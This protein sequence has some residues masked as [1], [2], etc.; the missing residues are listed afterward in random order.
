M[1]LC[2][3]Y[4]VLLL[5]C[6]RFAA[7]LPPVPRE[8]NSPSVE[9][10]F[11]SL[12]S[13]V[14]QSV[15]HKNILLS[16][17]VE[18]GDNGATNGP[19]GPIKTSQKEKLVI[20]IE[21]TSNGTLQT[22]PGG[23]QCSEGTSPEGQKCMAKG[24]LETLL[25]VADELRKYLGNQNGSLRD[26]TTLVTTSTVPP[27]IDTE[28]YKPEHSGCDVQR[29]TPPNCTCSGEQPP[30][31]LAVKDTPQL[32]ML[33]F[34]HT[35]HRGNMP[36]FTKL[37][38]GTHRRNKATGCDISVT[39]FVSADVDYKLMN[40]LYYLGNEIALHTISNRDDPDFWR[41]LSP[42]QWGRE[43][44][45]QR[46]MLKA[47]GNI[48]ERHVKGFSGPFLNTGGD[49]GFK[50]LQSNAVEYDNSL[51]HLRRRG[52]DFPLYPYTLDYGFKM[53]CVAEPCPQDRYPGLWVF[54][55]NVY[56]KSEVVDGRDREVPCPIGDA[57]EPQPVTANDTLHYLRSHFEQHYNTNRAPFQLSLSEE[58]L[59][60]P[61]RRKGYMAFVE[62]LLQKED[63]H[64]VTMSQA[65]EFMRKPEPLSSYNKR[66]C[67]KHDDRTPCSNPT[68]CSYPSTPLGNFRFMN[69]CSG[70][71]P[72]NFPWLKNPLGH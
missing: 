68:K 15:Q 53:P 48:A 11:A 64:L 21:R 58:W 61:K 65:L 47:F 66:Q 71:C 36:F 12:P 33:T 46:K 37:L 28:L 59:K 4:A 19:S 9:V 38:G 52:E 51:V 70:L 24:A 49:K 18:A 3:L 30:G 40:E 26:Q 5:G 55:V 22:S 14:D 25:S 72:R 63:V 44:S 34:N 6:L 32:V 43:V 42:E 29:C 67:E 10:N 27:K 13:N 35:V 50:A 17:T 20:T 56:L 8:T 23:P 1:N 41:S 16:H 60:D 57:C 39:F 2:R 54:P 62:W 7:S 45:D 31:G 69:T